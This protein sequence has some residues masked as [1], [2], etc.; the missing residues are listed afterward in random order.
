MYIYIYSILGIYTKHISWLYW[1][2]NFSL[3]VSI[4]A[5]LLSKMIATTK[6]ARITDVNRG[7]V[8]QLL[9]LHNPM[10]Y[11]VSMVVRT[12]A[13]GSNHGQTTSLESGVSSKSGW[14]NH[15]ETHHQGFLP[16]APLPQVCDADPGCFQ[17]WK[18]AIPKDLMLIFFPKNM[19]AVI[20]FETRPHITLLAEVQFA[21]WISNKWQSIPMLDK[22]IPSNLPRQWVIHTQS[23]TAPKQ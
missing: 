11:L 9:G 7:N 6:G 19:D 3:D 12:S 21:T 17:T 18:D 10:L 23:L 5:F 14:T 20:N 8:E 1:V 13:D 2:S 15:G 4:S 16:L 22:W